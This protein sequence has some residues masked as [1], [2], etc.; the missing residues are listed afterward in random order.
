MSVLYAPETGFAKERVK[1]EA[2]HTEMGPGL[3]PYVYR[4]Y[5]AMIYKAGRPAN[6]MG[7][8]II[9][10]QM[11]VGS[12]QEYENYRSRGFRRTP[13][14]AIDYL[15]KLRD[16]CAVLGAELNYEQKNKL[17]ENAA[18]EVEAARAVHTS[19]VSRHMPMKRFLSI[20]A[21]TVSF[22]PCIPITSSPARPTTTT[23]NRRTIGKSITPST[24][25]LLK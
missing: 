10:E 20:S 17:S 6:G 13:L 18:M 19:E 25:T 3:K 4:E 5:P 22:W 7:K 16:E 2:Q 1:W 12:E 14:E 23:P 24:K 9:E 21:I 8:H 15:D 11:T